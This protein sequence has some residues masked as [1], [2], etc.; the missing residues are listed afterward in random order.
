M[1]QPSRRSA[2]SQMIV[3]SK[4]IILEPVGRKRE[5]AMRAYLKALTVTVAFLGA[6]TVPPPE[7]VVIRLED[8]KVSIVGDDSAITKR[9]T[10][11]FAISYYEALYFQ[12]GFF[13]YERAYGDS[14]MSR[15][16][17]K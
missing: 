16:M 5:V 10:R 17:L 7:E 8:S 6:C 9:V 13:S 4:Q 14:G 2:D 15:S 12:G 11:A 1:R 3:K